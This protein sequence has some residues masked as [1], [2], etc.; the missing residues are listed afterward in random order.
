MS[1]ANTDLADLRAEHEA[2]RNAADNC[3]REVADIE[4]ELQ[5][6]IKGYNTIGRAEGKTVKE[7]NEIRCKN[8]EI[9]T[10]NRDMQTELKMLTKERD[11]TLKERAKASKI[12][13]LINKKSFKTNSE[14]LVTQREIDELALT[15]ASASSAVMQGRKDVETFKRQVKRQDHELDL[16]GR[17]LGLSK[18]ANAD[19]AD[20]TKGMI[21]RSFVSFLKM[22]SQH[23]SG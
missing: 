9:E 7:Q 6:C 20:I 16:V 5:T 17:K 13:E 15:S 21:S 23:L 1:V 19:V 14:R 18:R 3:I 11:F 4:A 10:G 12:R 8:Q 2:E 22:L